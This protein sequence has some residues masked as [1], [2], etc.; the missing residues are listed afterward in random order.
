MVVV[1]TIVPLLFPTLY[2][3]RGIFTRSPCLWALCPPSFIFKYVKIQKLDHPGRIITQLQLY[4]WLMPIK[5]TVTYNV[6]SNECIA[7]NG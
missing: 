3:K 6:T 1:V 4:L 5:Y 7:G 2:S